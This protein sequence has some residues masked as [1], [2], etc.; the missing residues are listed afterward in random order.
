M[1]SDTTITVVSVVQLLV[2]ISIV[3]YVLATVFH[4]FVRRVPALFYTA[5]FLGFTLNLAVVVTNFVVNKYVPFVTQYQ[6]MIFI[7]ALFM[8]IFFYFYKVYKGYWLGF[9]FSLAPTI[10]LIGSMFLIPQVHKQLPPAL[11]SP[12]FYPH[13][14]LYMLSYALLIVSFLISIYH[15]F[16]K[17]DK[18]KYTEFY[19]YRLTAIAFPFMTAALLM[20]AVW[21][22]QI[23]GH[24]W[25]WDIKENWSLIT[26]LFFSLY[27]HLRK[28]EKFKKFAIV[29]NILGFFAMMMTLFGVGF[30]PSNSEH[31]YSS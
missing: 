4:I 23:W 7:S 30:F 25:R 22:N 12:F 26:W 2:V 16:Q 6:V 29:F 13:V 10:F 5:F 27:L 9:F 31:V 24:F 11:Q 20:G 15:L 18:K 21:A 28:I 19:I 1:S 17:G 8:P 3:F 14:A